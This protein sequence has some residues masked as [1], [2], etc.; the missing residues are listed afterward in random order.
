MASTGPGFV[1]GFGG[2]THRGTGALP[3]NLDSMGNA[4]MPLGRVTRSTSAR[5]SALG[6]RHGSVERDRNSSSKRERSRDKSRGPLAPGEYRFNTAGPE[7][8]TDWADALQNVTD[9]VLTL[10]N[11]QR[12]QATDM[13]RV[14][15]QQRQC[16][17][18]LGVLS[19]QPSHN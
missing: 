9:R 19:S 14:E 1:M 10:E 11:N 17:E 3:V 2:G 5:L 7:E 6:H 16:G 12:K 13:A 15:H 4:T 18:Q 8:A